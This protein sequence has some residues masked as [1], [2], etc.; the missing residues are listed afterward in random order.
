MKAL[1][2]PP[3]S[4]VR[5]AAG[6]GL[7]VALESVLVANEVPL[8]A[9][10]LASVSTAV[11]LA[12]RRVAPATTASVI[13]VLLFL[14]MWL[15]D[16]ELVAGT[17]VLLVALVSVFSLAVY[18]RGRALVA[19]CVI[20][21]VAYNALALTAPE[22][23]FEDVLF[24]DVLLLVPAFAC[25]W[26]ARRRRETAA[27]LADVN[28]Q[29]EAER[30]AHGAAAAAEERTRLAGELHGAIAGG[31][32]AMVR[33]ADRAA[34]LVAADRTTAAERIALI[35]AVGRDTL[36]ELRGALGVLRRHDDALALAPQPTLTRLD[37]LA[38]RS[39][40]RGVAV[41]VGV[42]GRPVELS[43]GLDIA[44]YR[45][46]ED[47]LAADPAATRADV[48]VAWSSRRLSLDVRTDGPVLDERSVAGLRE[49]AA[50]FGAALQAGR[51]REGGSRVHV[52]LP[53]EEARA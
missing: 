47:A 49:R 29:L 7:L 3:A 16:A 26:V 37:A 41:D 11:P 35:E 23:D 33:E 46:V 44:A 24:I 48:A 13:A 18:G 34:A 27:R 15:A 20:G 1:P 36:D 50:L 6:L 21:L 40:A 32:A 53:L 42:T 28:A 12:W 19:A 14:E 2:R 52:D 9:A 38:E 17:L 4:D 39:R 22:T 25:G 8:A 10:A 43:A 30:G 51:R 31:V 5:L 45:L